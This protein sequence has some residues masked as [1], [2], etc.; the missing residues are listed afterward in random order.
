METMEYYN[1]SDDIKRFKSYYLVL[2]PYIISPVIADD[3]GLNRTMQY[4][5]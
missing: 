5:N 1:T 4:G 2:K 3:I